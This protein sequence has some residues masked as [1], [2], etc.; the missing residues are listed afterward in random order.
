MVLSRRQFRDYWN[1]RSPSLEKA[2]SVLWSFEHYDGIQP[3]RWF[4][5]VAPIDIRDHD[6]GYFDWCYKHCRGQVL[7][8][9][10]DSQRR[11]EWWGFTHRGDVLLWLLKWSQ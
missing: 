1:Q 9:N 6:T 4:S 2:D 7:C 5:C 8:Y 11:E 3:S 10:T